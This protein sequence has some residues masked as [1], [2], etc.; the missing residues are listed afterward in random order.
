MLADAVLAGKPGLDAPVRSPGAP[1][2]TRGMSW[3]QHR[4]FERWRANS[5]ATGATHAAPALQALAGELVVLGAAVA[6]AARASRAA[7]GHTRSHV[8]IRE[9]RTEHG[10]GGARRGEHA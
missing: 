8:G 10:R 9:G 3:T 1:V 7:D 6:E 2:L 4:I 5:K